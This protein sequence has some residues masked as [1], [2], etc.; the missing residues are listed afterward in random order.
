MI[1]KV[2][3]TPRGPQIM[4]RKRPPQMMSDKRCWK[5]LDRKW[6]T[7]VEKGSRDSRGGKLTARVDSTEEND[8]GVL[9]KLCVIY[10]K[11]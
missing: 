5:P 8:K 2:I 1:K 10:V 3:A 11:N 4:E 7:P 9:R 6:S